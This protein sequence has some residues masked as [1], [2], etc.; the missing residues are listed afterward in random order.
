M[1][2]PADIRTRFPEFA[3][4]S[5]SLIQQY[6]DDA[7]LEVNQARADI[8]YDLMIYYLV[9]HYLALSLSAT[10]G[11]NRGTGTV[12]SMSVGDT[13]ISFSSITPDGNID[14]YYQQTQYGIRFLKYLTFCSAGGMIV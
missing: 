13:S 6:L 14:F 3:A 10:S 1:I 7:Y 11:Q 4:L 5:D 9:A 12:G 8:Y 2:T